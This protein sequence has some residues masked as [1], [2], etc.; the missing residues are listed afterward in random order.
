LSGAQNLAAGENEPYAVLAG[1]VSIIIIVMGFIVI[2][3][4]QKNVLIY[5]LAIAFILFAT[6]TAI[7]AMGGVPAGRYSVCSAIIL[8]FLLLGIISGDGFHRP[9]QKLSF[10]VLAVPIL[11][12]AYEFYS[13][14]N[15]RFT[16]NVKGGAPDWAGEV[17]HWR[18]STDYRL[19]MWPFPRWRS[20][21]PDP[22]LTANLRE[23][24]EKASRKTIMLDSRHPEFKIQVNGLPSKFSFDFQLQKTDPDGLSSLEIVLAGST[25][26]NKKVTKV[27]EGYLEQGEMRTIEFNPEDKHRSTGKLRP[28]ETREITFRIRGLDKIGSGAINVSNIEYKSPYS[29]RIFKNID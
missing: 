17:S 7:L 12:G 8:G 3:K 20:Q 11:I 29:A 5:M 10:L 18:A 28:A 14:T 1:L 25:R 22:E 6:L 4:K 21:L 27:F 13:I 26:K 23:V 16:G 15:P 2:L 9:G 24:L 19:Q